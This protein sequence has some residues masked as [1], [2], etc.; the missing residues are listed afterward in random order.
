ML[1][2]D[3]AIAN[4]P[5]LKP[6]QV[7][8][9]SE[10]PGVLD[11]PRA[12]VLA[13]EAEFFQHTPAMVTTQT[14]MCFEVIVADP[15]ARAV[16]DRCAKARRD[17]CRARSPASAWRGAARTAVRATRLGGVFGDKM[18]EYCVMDVLALE[19]DMARDR[20]NQRGGSVA[21]TRRSSNQPYRRCATRRRDPGLRRI[22]AR[23]RG[24]RAHGR[25]RRRRRRSGTGIAGGAMWNPHRTRSDVRLQ[26]RMDDDPKASYSATS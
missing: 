16:R 2:P 7:L 11:A 20:E 13:R 9:L 17:G 25:A 8:V 6:T 1:D 18:A 4:A 12:C 15:V 3:D 21:A 23:R 19:R 14:P 5:R 26:C 24:V 22:G 10:V